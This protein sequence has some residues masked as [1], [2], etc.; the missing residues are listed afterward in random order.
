MRQRL[1]FT[2]QL[3]IALIFLSGLVGAQ[4]EETTHLPET[5]L[6]IADVWCLNSA[7]EKRPDAGCF[8][9]DRW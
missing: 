5:G 2:F 9:H 6:G 7:G 4:A 3:P 8:I 1:L